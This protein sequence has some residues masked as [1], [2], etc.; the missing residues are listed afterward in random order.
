MQVVGR[1]V[2][3]RRTR[4]YDNVYKVLSGSLGTRLTAC[5]SCGKREQEHQA[6]LQTWSDAST[7]ILRCGLNAAVSPRAPPQRNQKQ[8]G[9]VDAP[10]G[11]RPSIHWSIILNDPRRSS[12]E[13]ATSK[14][15]RERSIGSCDQHPDH[16]NALVA[17]QHFACAKEFRHLFCSP[18]DFSAWQLAA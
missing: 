13:P 7:A 12:L 9:T 17:G 16:P 4:S 10:S 1:A 2:P 14:Q 15:S 8:L 6:N 3:L 18:G 5:K 11:I